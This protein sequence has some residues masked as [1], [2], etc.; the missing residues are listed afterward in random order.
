[1]SVVEAVKRDLLRIARLDANLAESAE[2]Y[3]A[4][5][6]AEELDS[7]NSATSKSMCARAIS[8]LMASLREQCPEEVKGDGL[9]DLASRRRQRLEARG[10]DS[11][12]PVGS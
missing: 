2:A 8:E 4:L 5:A 1:M 6:L 10:S 11:Q 7:P 9:D 12:A 3:T